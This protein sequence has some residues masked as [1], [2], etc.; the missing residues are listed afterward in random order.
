LLCPGKILAPVSTLRCFQAALFKRNAGGQV[1]QS[2]IVAVSGQKP[3]P[4]CGEL[5]QQLR[6]RS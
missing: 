5:A 2:H 6:R 3:G 1:P 4:I